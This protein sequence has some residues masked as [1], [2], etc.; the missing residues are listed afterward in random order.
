MH[1]L[2]PY[3]YIVSSSCIFPR[4][5]SY[6]YCYIIC[7]VQLI[8]GRTPWC[9]RCRINTRNCDNAGIHPNAKCMKLR[10][11]PWNGFQGPQVFSSLSI[12]RRVQ[13]TLITNL[14]VPGL[15]SGQ[16]IES[17]LRPLRHPASK[18]KLFHIYSEER[19]YMYIQ[20]RFSLGA[21]AESLAGWNSATDGDTRSTV[22]STTVL[23][24]LPKRHVGTLLFR[25]NQTRSM[26]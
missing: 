9:P 2:N 12:V 7:S 14:Q 11:Q 1:V 22:T 6:T 13:I 18:F 10:F 15:L 19:C 20:P 17:F 3:W 4:A 5:S 24:S 25:D 23:A 8:G 26:I 21:W 16:L